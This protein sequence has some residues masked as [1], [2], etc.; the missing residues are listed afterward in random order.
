MGRHYYVL[1]RDR[2]DVPIRLCGEVLLR[3]L[4]NAPS[5]R[6][7]MFH[8]RRTSTSLRRT[9][10]PWSLLTGSV[11]TMYFTSN[12]RSQ[13]MFAYQPTL[14]TFELKEDKDIEYLLIWKSNRVYNSKL[15]PLYT[16]F[17]HSGKLSGYIIGI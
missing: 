14:D 8:L 13:N 17:L 15:K 1:L 3:R 6:C 16:A 12:D 7:W 11:G 2:Y 5:R 10:R 4:G 9:K